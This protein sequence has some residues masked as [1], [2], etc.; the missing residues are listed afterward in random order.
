MGGRAVPGAR[1]V[2]IAALALGGSSCG[3]GGDEAAPAG[4]QS[5][6]TGAQPAATGPLADLRPGGP[7]FSTMANGGIRVV[8][9]VGN[10]GTARARRSTAA[11]FLSRRRT[12]QAWDRA[13]SR[14]AL[15]AL[16]PGATSRQATTL[17]PPRSLGARR[18]WVI[19]CADVGRRTRESSERNN[20]RSSRRQVRLRPRSSD[21][22]APQFG[23]IASATT[24]IPGPRGGPA[25][26]SRSRLEW[27]AASDDVT[28]P[29]ELVYDV[30]QGKGA[31]PDF[32]RPAYTTR[33]GATSFTTPELSS[34]VPWHFGVRARD[35]AG[36][37]D[38][39]RVEL[40]SMNIC[41]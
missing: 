14:F 1:I 4:A 34:A 7:S 23:G 8:V 28:A 37:R 40:E 29:A 31:N 20:C 12:R 33:A 36:N 39:N 30:Y 38:G 10:R 3:A 15:G 19:A 9:T 16:R 18:F 24:C 11:V 6:A 13:L 27:K 32:S 26:S 35:E 5:A 41:R 22:N 2:L 21:R 17:R 25:V